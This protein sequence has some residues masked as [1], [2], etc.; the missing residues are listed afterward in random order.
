M[1]DPYEGDPRLV[2]GLNG[3]TMKFV[4]GQPVMDRGLENFS[5]ISLLTDTGW[6]GNF[7]IKDDAE[8]IG[9]DFEET[10]LETRTLSSLTRIENSAER[11][12]SNPIFESVDIDVVN[13][14]SF[15][16]D[17]NI[18]L[19][20]PNQDTRVLKLSKNSANWQNQADEPAS[21]RI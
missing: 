9:S 21:R 5:L 3:T 10:A 2:L 14:E 11:A 18:L 8:K 7:F 13:P 20:P 12:L 4:G 1:I 15:F 16:I 6:A 17:V 19:K